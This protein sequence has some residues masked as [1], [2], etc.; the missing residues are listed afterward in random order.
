VT[1]YTFAPRARRDLQEAWTYSRDR[2][3][4]QRADTYIRD[5]TA[6]VEHIAANP[7]LGQACDEIQA[8]YRK[9]PAGSH[10]LF[11]VIRDDAIVVIRVLHQQMDVGDKL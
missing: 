9:H 2:W 6:I 8:G 11:Y 7:S 4:R 1:A 10:M 5:L 3:G